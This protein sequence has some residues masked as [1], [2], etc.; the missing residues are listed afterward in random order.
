MRML[1]DFK[2]PNFKFKKIKMKNV[3]NLEEVNYEELNKYEGNQKNK[4]YI[5]D[6]L[7]NSSIYLMTSH[8]ESFG[9]VLIEAMSFGIP[10]IAYSSAQ[11]AN[12]IITNEVDGYLIDNR[13]ED[14]MLEKIELLVNDEKLRN[15]LG[16]NARSKSKNFSSEVILDKWSKLINKRK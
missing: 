16:K 14:E 2:V 15:K 12:E 6:L 11:G 9:I 3:E 5:N 4:E 1:N 8:T 7:L 10:C 13:N